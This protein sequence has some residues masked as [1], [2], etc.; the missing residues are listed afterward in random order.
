M[1][2]QLLPFL[3]IARRD[4]REAETTANHSGRCIIQR[5]IPTINRNILGKQDV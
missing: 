2:D 4:A 1:R 5:E 3:G